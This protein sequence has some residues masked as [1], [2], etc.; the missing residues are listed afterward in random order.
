MLCDSR[1]EVGHLRITWVDGAAWLI[2]ATLRWPDIQVYLRAFETVYVGPMGG[3]A[4]GV[5]A[6]NLY[7]SPLA[8]PEERSRALQLDNAP[9]TGDRRTPA[10]FH[11]YRNF[12]NGKFRPPD[13][14]PG[15]EPAA[16]DLGLHNVVEHVCEEWI[17]A[18]REYHTRRLHKPRGKRRK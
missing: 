14:A 2:E 13:K 7:Y 4:F 11:Q 1:F 8:P 15:R 6:Y 17:P 12:V 3:F 10:E 16:C 18:L 9:T 5:C